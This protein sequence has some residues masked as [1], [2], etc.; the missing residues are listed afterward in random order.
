M[1]TDNDNVEL[2]ATLQEL[3][4]NLL[5]DGVKT[6]VGVGTDLFSGGHDGNKREDGEVNDAEGWG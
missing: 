1:P 6:D 2:E 4:L 3:V 5:R